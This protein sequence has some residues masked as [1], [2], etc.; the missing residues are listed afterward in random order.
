MSDAQSADVPSASKPGAPIYY[1]LR[2]YSETT[3]ALVD[4]IDTALPATR[5]RDSGEVTFQ[6]LQE[7]L[8]EL[9][10]ADFVALGG[11]LKE[12]ISGDGAAGELMGAL[13]ES[14]IDKPWFQPVWEVFDKGFMRRQ[15]EPILLT[16]ILVASIAELEQLASELV[17]SFYRLKPAALNGVKGDGEPEFS[18]QDLLDLGS[19]DDAISLA[20]QRRVDNL[21]YQGVGSWRTYFREKMNIDVLSLGGDW[22]TI[23][24]IFERRNVLVH[25]GGM[26]TE[27]YVRFA[28]NTLKTSIA[29]GSDLEPDEEYV[30][31]AITHL[32]TFGVLLLTSVNAKVD[33]ASGYMFPLRGLAEES[34]AALRHG[35][36]SCSLILSR[37]MQDYAVDTADTLV[38]RINEAL[39]LKRLGDREGMLK[40]ADSIDVSAAS[41]SYRMARSAL[42]D[43]LDSVFELLPV[44]ISS[45]ELAPRSV[46]EWP[47]LEEARA[48]SRM[49][50]IAPLIRRSWNSEVPMFRYNERTRVLHRLDCPRATELPDIAGPPS[51][52][53]PCGSC[54]PER[55]LEAFDQNLLEQASAPL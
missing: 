8:E 4:L 1:Q 15:R 10:S 39:S 16:S 29:V 11:L 43:D 19:I 22:S 52:A 41:G 6:G 42:I 27:R 50:V 20:V 33:G 34:Y 25:Q 31:S 5:D 55:S 35:W 46:I 37:A 45:D 28:K 53:K 54:H 18:L 32:H 44:L 40:I 3:L 30:R 48:D 23:L 13:V 36:Y 51:E 47:L 7:L 24:E 26:A 17:R 21:M 9:P 12:H 2:R 38:A 14:F 49:E